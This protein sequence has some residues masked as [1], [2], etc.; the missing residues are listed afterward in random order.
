MSFSLSLHVCLRCTLRPKILQTKPTYWSTIWRWPSMRALHL[1]LGTRH[2]WHRTQVGDAI[3]PLVLQVCKFVKREL[4]QSH[5]PSPKGKAT[6]N[7]QQVGE[8]HRRAV[9]A[10]AT[11]IQDTRKLESNSI[12]ASFPKACLVRTFQKGPLM[13]PVSLLLV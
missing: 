3:V 12:P 9:T 2:E 1:D 13:T 5:R 11:S 4:S 8:L 7:S 10:P 6:N